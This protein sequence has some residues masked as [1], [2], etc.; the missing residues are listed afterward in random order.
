MNTYTI[1]ILNISLSTLWYKFIENRITGKIQYWNCRLKQIL[2]QLPSVIY[3]ININLKNKNLR[4]VSIGNSYVMM[5]ICL[6]ITVYMI[7]NYYKKHE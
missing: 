6:L 1:I 4:E 3:V 7:L 5:T 2:L